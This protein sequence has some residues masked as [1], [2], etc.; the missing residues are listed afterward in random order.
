VIQLVGHYFEGRRPA[1]VDNLLQSLMAPL[2][3]IAEVLF[4]FGFRKELLD[5]VEAKVP[6]FAAR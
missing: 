1:L 5:A 3:L 6:H 4:H 2:F